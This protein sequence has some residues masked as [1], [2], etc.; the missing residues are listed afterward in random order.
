MDTEVIFIT[1][2]DNTAAGQAYIT[3]S[4]PSCG[5]S[6]V[7]TGTAVN[8]RPIFSGSWSMRTN[9]T[10]QSTEAADS[11]ILIPF[12]FYWP[13][14]KCVINGCKIGRGGCHQ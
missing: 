5:Y 2:S 14:K 4:R 1:G 11:S 8:T 12:A 9:A 7:H 10:A 6:G 13:V 3:A